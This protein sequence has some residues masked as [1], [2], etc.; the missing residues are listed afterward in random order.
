MSGSAEL[1]NVDNHG[2]AAQVRV[3]STLAELSEN[4]LATFGRHGD[5][6]ITRLVH[7][8]PATLRERLLNRLVPP[9]DRPR[10]QATAERLSQDARTWASPMHAHLSSQLY[11]SLG[12]TVASTAPDLNDF[13]LQLLVRYGLWCYLLDDLLDN[14]GNVP[15]HELAERVEWVLTTDRYAKES[16]LEDSLA[17]L[18]EALRQHDHS[19]LRMPRFTAGLIDAVTAGAAHVELSQRVAAGVSEPPTA[20]DYLDLAAR[21]IN[22]RSF[23]LALLVVVPERPSTAALDRCDEALEW[24]SIAI[25]LANDLSTVDK[26]RHEGSLNILTLRRRNGAA[27][28]IQDVEYEI[29]RHVRR[30][31]AIL[32]DLAAFGLRKSASALRNSLR[33]A[34]GAYRV[35]DLK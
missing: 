33:V 9:A 30:H 6:V 24:A 22:Y 4:P 26:D 23:A 7:K 34:I 28:T 20:E 10:V 17:G 12:L 21:H 27:V 1:S 3:S 14:S 19:G 35:A 11:D 25:R 31:D 5:G 29:D 15:P 8:D 16:S 2:A 13:R 18:L 32:D